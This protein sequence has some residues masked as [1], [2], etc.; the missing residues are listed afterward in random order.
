MSYYDYEESG[1]V[2]CDFSVDVLVMA[3]MR[4]ADSNNARKLRA[5]YPEVWQEL[6]DRYNAPGGLLDGEGA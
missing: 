6:Q 3:A 4:R 5:A 2:S 1:Q